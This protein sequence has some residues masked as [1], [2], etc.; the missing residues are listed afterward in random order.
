MVFVP[1]DKEPTHA[2]GHQD[3]AA[4]SDLHASIERVAAREEAAAKRL[5]RVR[6]P[7]TSMVLSLAVV[8]A[9]VIALILLVP[10]VNSVTQP[11]VNVELGARAAVTKVDFTPSVPR[12]LPDGWRAT[13]VR[14]TRSTADVIMWHVGYQTDSGQYAA[15][16][17]AAD[18]P[19]EWVRQQVNRVPKA[20][21][22]V[23]EGRTW[24]QWVRPD[25]VQN[26][27]VRTQ[28]RVTTVLT[29]TATFDELATLAASLE[30]AG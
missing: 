2:T 27:L 6:A 23:I 14:T 22:Q 18:A 12:G 5:R 29:G 30:P 17:Q 10:R 13:S 8:L 21:E 25:K 11:P 20:G 1:D 28:G 15:V 9:L 16:Q 4:N 19:F 3:S 26:S 24:Q 7:W